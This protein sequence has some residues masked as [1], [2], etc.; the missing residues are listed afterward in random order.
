VGPDC[1]VEFT[2]EQAVKRV[3]LTVTHDLAKAFDCCATPAIIGDLQILF[4]TR[5]F[6]ADRQQITD[7]LVVDF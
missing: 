3:F 7:L 1:A 2:F 6:V 5:D 4:T